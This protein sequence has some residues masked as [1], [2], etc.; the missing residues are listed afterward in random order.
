LAV[1]IE[2]SAGGAAHRGEVT[3][4]G[5]E[6]GTGIWRLELKLGGETQRLE[7]RVGTFADEPARTLE[8]TLRRPANDLALAESVAWADE[9]GGDELVCS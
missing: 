5:G 3:R 7:Q 1:E 9:L 8:R 6:E 2:A 4:T